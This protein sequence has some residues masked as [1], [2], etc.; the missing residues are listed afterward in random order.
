MSA[1]GAMSWPQLLSR[2]LSGQTLQTTETQWAMDVIMDGAATPAQIAGFAVALRAKGETAQEVRG[3]VDAMLTHALPLSIEGPTLDVVGTGGDLS[4][5]VNVST[6]AAVVAA[7]CGA[8]VV[9]HGNR[10][11]S[12][13]CGSAD[14][15]QELGVRIDLQPDEVAAVLDKVGITFCF[16]PV[17]HS[18]LRHAGPPRR[19]LGV[20]TVFNILGPLANPARPSAQLVGCADERLA[21]VMAEVLLSMGV[22]AL[23]VRGADG[24]DEISTSGPTRVWDVRGDEVVQT[25]IDPTT[26]GIAPASVSALRGGD[27]QFNAAVAQAVFAG[28]SSPEIAPVRDAVALNAAAALVALDAVEQ[29]VQELQSAIAASLQKVRAVLDQGTAQSVLKTWVEVSSQY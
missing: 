4:H 27:A 22:K 25:T 29:P 20:P 3:L 10:A 13:S 21:P 7:A 5:S 2:L 19:E 15:L 16:A 1:A 8:R 14:V 6:M 9:K 23:V 28:D 11:A 18:A 26:L 12:S 24:L 17:F